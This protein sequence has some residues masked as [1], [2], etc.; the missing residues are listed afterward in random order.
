MFLY[1]SRTQSYQLACLRNGHVDRGLNFWAALVHLNDPNLEGFPRY[2]YVVIEVETVTLK[3]RL[4]LLK[5][6]SS[7]VIWQHGLSYVL[8]TAFV[9]YFKQ[10]LLSRPYG[11]V[12]F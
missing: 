2:D 12:R 10:L 6:H 3:N 8:N 4:N 9:N 5:A 1:L 7:C 11:K